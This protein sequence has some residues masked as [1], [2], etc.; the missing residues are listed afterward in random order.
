M[1]GLTARWQRYDDGT[2]A[3]PE[4][5]QRFIPGVFAE[6]TAHP[7]SSVSLLGG[8]RLDHQGDHGTIL[9]PRATVRY[10]PWHNATL[11]GSFGT[12]FRVVNL[13]TEDHAALTGARDVVIA[14]GLEP[15]RSRSFAFNY[16]Q[17]IEFGVNNM[18]IDLDFIRTCAANAQ[19]GSSHLP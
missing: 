13:F 11:R 7:T 8:L 2:P 9:A 16:N 5:D 4:A 1:A 10:T 18:M 14:E 12:G 19:V 15:E 6:A 17:I 3:T